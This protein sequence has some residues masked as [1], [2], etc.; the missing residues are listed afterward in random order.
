MII[1]LLIIIGTLYLYSRY[2][3]IKHKKTIKSK[4]TTIIHTDNKELDTLHRIKNYFNGNV[5]ILQNYNSADITFLAYIIKYWRWK[6][7]FSKLSKIFKIK[8]IM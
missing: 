2:S 3:N 4:F 7:F 5:V 1:I 8:A 6:P